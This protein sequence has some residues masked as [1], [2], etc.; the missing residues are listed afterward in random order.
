MKPY[1]KEEFNALGDDGM[2]NVYRLLVEHYSSSSNTLDA[3]TKHLL[4]NDWYAC[5]TGSDLDVN[6]ILLRT[7]R[8]KYPD[9]NMSWANKWKKIKQIIKS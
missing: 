7:I 6:P 2:F 3:I 5:E 9:V 8:E 1:T 4:G